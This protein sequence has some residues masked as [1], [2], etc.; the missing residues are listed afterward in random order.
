MVIEKTQIEAIVEVLQARREKLEE[1]DTFMN[2]VPSHYV[3]VAI[4]S[5]VIK[6]LKGLMYIEISG[7]S[8]TNLPKKNQLCQ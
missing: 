5:D 1:R 4:Y 2:D 8:K 7:E 3:G 6:K